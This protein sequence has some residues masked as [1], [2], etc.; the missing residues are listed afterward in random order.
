M[1]QCTD[2]DIIFYDLKDRNDLMDIYKSFRVNEGDNVVE[3]VKDEE[4]FIDSFEQSLSAFINYYDCTLPRMVSQHFRQ[5]LIRIIKQVIN[6]GIH[7][8]PLSGKE[9][10]LYQMYHKRI[11][12]GKNNILKI[13]DILSFE[14]FVRYYN[15]FFEDVFNNSEFRRESLGSKLNILTGI[16][17]AFYINKLNETPGGLYDI[18]KNNLPD[19]AEFLE[20][21]KEFILNIG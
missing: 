5:F 9:I 16:I 3:L 10:L 1:D 20:E 13:N 6:S 4:I 19:M 12:L 21:I 18:D 8:N 14:D 17:E 2:H 11:D 15:D 7:L